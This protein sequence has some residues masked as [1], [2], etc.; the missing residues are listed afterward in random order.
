MTE[1]VGSSKQFFVKARCYSSDL[2]SC[3]ID[4]V[5]N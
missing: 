5:M 3:L 1:L 4:P 2:P